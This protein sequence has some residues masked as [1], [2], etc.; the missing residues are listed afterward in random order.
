[1][2]NRTSRSASRADTRRTFVS[3]NATAAG[4][5]PALPRRYSNRAARSTGS[6]PTSSSPRRPARAA[7]F[8]RSCRSR[9][10]RVHA[11]SRSASAC[12]TCQAFTTS[13]SSLLNR[14]VDSANRSM[15]ASATAPDSRNGST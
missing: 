2:S 7:R 3:S 9:R 13:G 15:K 14:K 6:I 4:S 11:T 5:R 10:A 12:N 1:M 8:A